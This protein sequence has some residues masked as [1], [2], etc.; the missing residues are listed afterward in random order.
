MILLFV[1]MMHP[2]H[3]TVTELEWNVDSRRVEVAIR[4]DP[5]DE[6]WLAKTSGGTVGQS[7]WA[8]KYLAKH[9]QV[10]EQKQFVSERMENSKVDKPRHSYRWIGRKSEGAHVWWYFEIEP[11]NRK[12]PIWI[13]Q[14]MLFERDDRYAN[15]VVVLGT[16]PRRA[17]TLTAT[18]PIER[19]DRNED[20]SRATSDAAE[21]KS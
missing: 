18:K 16:S 2:V 15:R 3:E 10:D 11:R 6:Q 7:D 21:P 19:L 20:E 14:D 13:R 8:I 1:L 4:L 5:L 17:I 9:F 12:R